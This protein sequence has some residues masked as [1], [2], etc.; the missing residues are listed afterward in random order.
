[1]ALLHGHPQQATEAFCDWFQLSFVAKVWQT[2]DGDEG[3]P[4]LALEKCLLSNANEALLCSRIPIH[5]PTW[6]S[7]MPPIHVHSA[8]SCFYKC[9]PRLVTINADIR[10]RGLPID[11]FEHALTR[12]M[13]T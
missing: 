13:L 12:N 9:I 8:F 2:A 11:D 5:A 4:A 10:V 1:M 7:S 6:S 3:T